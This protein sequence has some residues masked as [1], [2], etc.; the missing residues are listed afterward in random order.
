MSS[1]N[2]EGPCDFLGVENIV[3]R[4][5]G[6]RKIHLGGGGSSGGRAQRVADQMEKRHKVGSEKRSTA[7][8]L[9]RKGGTNQRS[10]LKKKG[11]SFVGRGALIPREK[12]KG[13]QKQEGSDIRAGEKRTYTSYLGWGEGVS[14]TGTKFSGSFS[15][16]KR[17]LETRGHR[18]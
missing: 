14:E 6:K 13:S 4:E 15:I 11:M 16:G 8:L 2:L 12:K 1:L 5:E 17:P 7:C 18:T 10:L 3:G 9:Q